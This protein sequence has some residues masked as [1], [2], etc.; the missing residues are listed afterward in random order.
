[1]HPPQV[2]TEPGEEQ[3][4]E[5]QIHMPELQLDRSG[6]VSSGGQFTSNPVQYSGGSHWLRE[7]RHDSD[8]PRS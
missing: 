4:P 6:A 1:M 7:Y 5:Q 8:E 3:V 2:S